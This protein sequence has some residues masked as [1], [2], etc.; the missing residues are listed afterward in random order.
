[1]LVIFRTLTL[2][3]HP[4]YLESVTP[5]NVVSSFP[6]VEQHLFL[7]TRNTNT[8]IWTTLME[9]PKSFNSLKRYY[10]FSLKEVS[11]TLISVLCILGEIHHISHHSPTPPDQGHQN[12]KLTK[13]R[14]ASQHRITLGAPELANIFPL[15][16][17]RW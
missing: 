2:A 14:K 11:Y 16:L 17:E 3:L 12:T 6:K 13:G 1:M 9:L 5:A 8:G 7:P 10:F 4:H 15:S